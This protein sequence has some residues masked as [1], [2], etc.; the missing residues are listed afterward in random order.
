MNGDVTAL[1]AALDAEPSALN[2]P[3][4]G[5]WTALHLASHF[6]H[7]ACVDLL[8]ARGADVH[9]RSGNDMRNLAT[10]AAAAGR[11]PH[12]RARILQRLIEAGTPVDETQEGGYTALHGACQ[13]ADQ[14]SIDLLVRYG[15]DLNKPAD[16]GRTPDSLRRS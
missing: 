15:A 16:D 6:G 5:G 9:A 11:V 10:H 7:I 8:L 14:A 12:A 1:G 13:N 2:Q 4:P 3:G